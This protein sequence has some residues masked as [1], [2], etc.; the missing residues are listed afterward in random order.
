MSNP[1]PL[2]AVP[3]V[4][5][6]KAGVGNLD[7][8]LDQHAR[9][10]EDAL[11][12]IPRLENDIDDRLRRLGAQVPRA[13]RMV[14][15]GSV[16]PADVEHNPR[17][18]ASAGVLCYSRFNETRTE[19]SSIIR[20]QRLRDMLNDTIS[21]WC[22]LANALDQL[23]A[24]DAY[25]RVDDDGDRVWVG[26]QPLALVIDEILRRE[27]IRRVAVGLTILAEPAP[28]MAN[29]APGPEQQTGVEALPARPRPRP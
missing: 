28:S 1:E 3:Q 22:N 25:W 19:R 24:R 21:A 14:R 15:S 11:S 2:N 29:G 8:Y 7:L 10:V 12:S 17:Q 20:C 27:S 9:D 26:N 16:R 4:G 5:S 6:A 18:K 23:A 13:H